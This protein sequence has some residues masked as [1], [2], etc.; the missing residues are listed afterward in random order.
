M[1]SASQLPSMPP[2]ASRQQHAY[3]VRQRFQN[4]ANRDGALFRQRE[5]RCTQAG[6]SHPQ[7]SQH[8][9]FHP[10]GHAQGLSPLRTD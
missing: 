5:T 6:Q 7:P 9:S 1:T 4:S 8:P 3:V 10:A 2:R